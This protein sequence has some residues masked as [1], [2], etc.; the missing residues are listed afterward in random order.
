VRPE[1][2][3]ETALLTVEG[4]TARP[5]DFGSVE[6]RDGRITFRGRDWSVTTATVRFA[7]PRR[8]DPLLDVLATSRIA[9]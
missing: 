2:I 4:T 9:E 6:S 1:R 8:L 7:D 5:V 3:T